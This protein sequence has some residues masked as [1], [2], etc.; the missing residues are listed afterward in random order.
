ML[1]G[2]LPPTAPD[3]IAGAR[4][5]TLAEKGVDV[6]ARLQALVAKG[7]TVQPEQRYQSVD[8][9]LGDLQAVLGLAGNGPASP[10]AVPAS[11]P[12]R[13]QRKT[14][15]LI[16]AFA[17]ALIG[18][19]GG[20]VMLRTPPGEPL[21]QNDL[22]QTAAPKQ[23]AVRQ[24]PPQGQPSQPAQQ[25]AERDVPTHDSAQPVPAPV[26]SLSSLREYGAAGAQTQIQLRFL[27]MR[28]RRASVSLE[29]LNAIS[30]KT[31]TIDRL[32]KTEEQL[33][34]SAVGD[35]DSMISKYMSGVEWLGGHNQASVDA[36]LQLEHDTV[37]TPS[38]D[39][40]EADRK[41]EIGRALG[42]LNSH[43]SMLRQNK[44]TKA[45]IIADLDV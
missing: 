14:P 4:L 22:P 2:D 18:A 32:I 9:F 23:E 27:L 7:M 33:Y 1:T 19:V 17:V 39:K 6:P 20:V 29:K 40:A 16:G 28:A 26:S 36:A 38:V 15:L 21:Q 42:L 13:S 35:E 44:L 45:Q 11:P 24:E 8:D 37:G 41:A 30:T 3:R 12:N 31:E 43:L 34:H 10:R 25:R 5:P